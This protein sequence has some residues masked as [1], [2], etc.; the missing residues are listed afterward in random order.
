MKKHI[1]LLVVVLS[2]GLMFTSCKQG[3]KTEGSEEKSEVPEAV[4]KSFQ[5]KFAQASEVKWEEEEGTYEAEFQ[6]NGKEMSAEF[7]GDGT[8]METETEVDQADLP[9]AIV[10]TLESAYGD[11]TVEKVESCETPEGK[12]W[13]IELKK[14]DTEME[15]VMDE[16]GKILKKEAEEEGE[17]E[18][19]E[20]SEESH[21]SGEVKEA[22]GEQEKGE[23]EEQEEE[24]E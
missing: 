22:G 3:K 10:D 12:N 16:N 14:D 1:F 8:W 5:E 24:K 9:A 23:K 2:A 20:S 7:S 19:A 21:E 6:L 17:A 13:E 4:Q 11:Y 18:V 15:L